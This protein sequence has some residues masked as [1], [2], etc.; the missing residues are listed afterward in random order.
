MLKKRTFFITNKL[1]INFNFDESAHD[2]NARGLCNVLNCYGLLKSITE[3]TRIQGKSKTIMDNIFSNINIK[4]LDPTIIYYD[5]SDHFMQ[6]ISY[7][8][9]FDKWSITKFSYQGF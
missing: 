1:T 9:Q 8:C 4:S 6:I 2:I 5:L 3:F 7:P